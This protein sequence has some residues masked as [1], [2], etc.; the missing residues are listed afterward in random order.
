M[1]MRLLKGLGHDPGI[2][3]VELVGRVILAEAQR[4][5]RPYIKTMTTALSLR[6]LSAH[7]L[8]RPWLDRAVPV[9]PKWRLSARPRYL[10]SA[11]VERLIAPCDLTKPH[12]I[13]DKAILLLLARL[14]LRAGDILGMRIDD[15][16]GCQPHLDPA[17][18]WDHRRRLLCQETGSER[19]ASSFSTV[20]VIRIRT[21]AANSISIMLPPAT[22]PLAGKL[23]TGGA[24]ATAAKPIA[25]VGAGLAPAPAVKTPCWAWRCHECSRLG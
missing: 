23:G 16:A 5:S 12:G 1:L 6:Y 17:R 9:I 10:P 4:S 14:G 22:A 2:Y 19:P 25:S 13:R 20:P 3:D 7:G 11:D 24:T 8:C 15:I 18:D 21:P